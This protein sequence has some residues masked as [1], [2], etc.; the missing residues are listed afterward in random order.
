MNG[1]LTEANE[2]WS[3]PPL[4]IPRGLARKARSSPTYWF[5]S[6]AMSAKGVP[7]GDAG[8]HEPGGADLLD[9]LF[10]AGDVIGPHARGRGIRRRTAG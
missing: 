7:F 4:P 6:R 10:G 1:S 8:R 9:Q 5:I 2:A 3:E